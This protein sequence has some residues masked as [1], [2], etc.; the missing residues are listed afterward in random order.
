MAASMVPGTGSYAN[1]A[2]WITLI[3]IYNLFKVNRT[4]HDSRLILNVF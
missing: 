4:I 2:W 3:V 1:L